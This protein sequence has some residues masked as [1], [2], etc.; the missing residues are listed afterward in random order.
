MRQ[1]EIAMGPTSFIWREIKPFIYFIW[2][3]IFHFK[4]WVTWYMSVIGILLEHPEVICQNANTTLIHFTKSFMFDTLTHYPHDLPSN[5]E[6]WRTERWFFL[7][8]FAFWSILSQH[9]LLSALEKKAKTERSC[10]PRAPDAGQ[11]QAQSSWAP[12]Q[13]LEKGAKKR[14]LGCLPQPAQSSRAV[15]QVQLQSCSWKHKGVTEGQ[16][17]LQ[18]PGKCTAGHT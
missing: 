16:E 12:H 15:L 18:R 6:N 1:Q 11:G 10:S 14:S 5:R 9:R 8:L 3:R 17:W 13:H 4:V 7:I 2:E